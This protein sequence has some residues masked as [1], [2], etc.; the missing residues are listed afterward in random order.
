MY[1]PCRSIDNIFVAGFQLYDGMTV[2][3]KI[4]PG[5]KLEM[6]AEPDNPYDP[7]A[8]KL[9]FGGV[10]LGYVPKEKNGMAALLAFYGHAD[11]LECVVTQVDPEADPWKQVRVSLFVTDARER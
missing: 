10:K 1:E 11:V 7:E 3:G 8:V 4:K 5:A 2:V 6:V 9:C